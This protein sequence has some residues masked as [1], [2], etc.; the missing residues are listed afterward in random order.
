MVFFGARAIFDTRKEPPKQPPVAQ[1]IQPPAPVLIP[2]TEK[3]TS[4]QTVVR[5]GKYIRM[6]FSVDTEKMQDVRVIGSFH[7]SGGSGNDIQVVLAEES[8]FE[9]WINGHQAR[10]LY[11]TEK[12]TNDKMDVEI[13][14]SGTYILAFSNTYSL[15]TD[16]DV[17]AEVE[18]HYK[19]LRQM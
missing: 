11:S 7:A 9:N 8:E 6:K 16:K 18:L 2:V 14:Q 10:A 3:L 12:I 15:L 1:S 4:G 19:T 17:F 13:T 5:A